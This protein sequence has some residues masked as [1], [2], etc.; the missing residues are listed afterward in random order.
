M[1]KH[2]WWAAAAGLIAA[3]A[4][5]ALVAMLAGGD[6]D[7]RA[8]D[9]TTTTS[10]STTSTSV[11]TIDSTSSTSAP[12]TSSTPTAT[13]APTTTAVAPA[14]VP[15][16]VTVVR[17]YTGAGSG[18]VQVD[19]D[20]VPGA[21]GYRIIRPAGAGNAPTVMAEIDVMTGTATAL[22]PVANVW[23]EDRN[24]LPPRGPWTGPDPSVHFHYVDLGEG[25]RC[26]Q[27]IAFNA[28]G[29]GPP[30]VVVCGSPP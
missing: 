19:W 20:A 7:D 30:S 6:D 29:D 26:F 22:P 2:W 12:P 23:S 13:A 8:S 11:T 1:R 9:R 25:E 4:V 3:V 15:G 24:Y 17:T 18:E 5:I 10:S 21:T 14:P 28:A 16:A 27:V